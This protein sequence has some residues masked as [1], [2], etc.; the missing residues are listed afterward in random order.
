[1]AIKRIIAAA[2]AV[3]LLVVNSGITFADVTVPGVVRV[4]LYYGGTA[5][6]KFSINAQK[7]ISIGFVKDGIFTSMY[8]EPSNNNIT[9]R[10][11]A[12]YTKS[13]AVFTEYNPG[14]AAPSGDKVGPFHIQLNGTFADFNSANIQ[15]QTYKQQGINAYPV[16]KDSWQLWS[17]FYSDQN[18]AQADI[19]IIQQ[20][21]GA[22]NY[23][24]IQPSATRIAV[25]NA[26]GDTVL[27]FDSTAAFFQIH[28]KQENNPY[29]FCLNNKKSYRGNLEVRRQ[30]GSDMTLINVLPLDQYVYGV[31][32]NEIESYSNAE[33]LKAQAVA[34]RTYALDNISYSKHAKWNFDVCT[35]TDCQ[36]YGGYSTETAATDKA[37]DDTGGLKVTYNGKLAEVFFFASDGGKTEEPKNVWGTTSSIP[38]LVSVDDQYESTSSSHYNWSETVSA[39]EIK[40]LTQKYGHDIGDITGVVAS[41]YSEAGRVTELDIYGTNSVKPYA[42]YLNSTSSF[43]GLNSQM[44]TVS[45]NAGISVVSSDST[46][47]S[48][49]TGEISVMTANGIVK[50]PASQSNLTVLGANGQ[51]KTVNAAPTAYT[52]TGKGWGHGVGMSQEGAKGMANAGFKFDQILQ[53][54]FPGTKVE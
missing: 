15:A 9:V 36:V 20:K 26:N 12:Y 43:F 46:I 6:S 11:D 42:L 3:V 13:G 51:T 54:Y 29:I 28:P 45:S 8:E 14:S 2:V 21:L 35:T 41:K 25:N 44:F 19:A 39:D 40:A 52:F 10:K 37:V 27:L 1:M 16:Y 23:T 7:G 33:A 4:G 32:P 48:I 22:G 38:Y 49:S 50:I 17:G 18:S 24:V 47:K 30:S 53:H 34:A 31:V 5:Q